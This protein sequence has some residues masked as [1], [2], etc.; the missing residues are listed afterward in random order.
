MSVIIHYVEG[1]DP[2]NGLLDTTN[3]SNECVSCKDKCQITFQVLVEKPRLTL[4]CGSA[5]EETLRLTLLRA[6]SGFQCGF[7]KKFEVEEAEELIVACGID[8][9]NNETAKRMMKVALSCVQYKQESRPVMSVVVKMLKD[10]EDTSIR[11]GVIMGLGIAYAGSQNEQLP[12]KLTG[13]LNDSKASLDV[14][15]FTAISLGLI[16]VGSCNEEIAQAIIYTV[17]DRSESELGEPLTRLLPLGLGLLYIG[18]Q[19]QN[20][21]GHCLQHLHKCK[22]HQGPGVLGIAMVAVAEELGLERT[23]RSLEHLLQY[24]EQNIRRAVPLALGLLCISNPKVNVMDTLS[25]LS[26]DTDSEVAI[27]R[28]V[29]SL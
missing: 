4:Q 12:E 18:K 23:I 26:H 17:M 25:R 28:D 15:A 2:P 10:K 8:D 9:Q 6:R 16:F 19:V 24:G 5:G 3:S 29:K 7:G 13:V 21:L 27:V 14:L 20:L 22:T 1:S 11:I